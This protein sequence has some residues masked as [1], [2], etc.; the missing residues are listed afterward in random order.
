[1]AVIQLANI[2]FAE[3]GSMTL[4]DMTKYS[5]FIAVGKVMNARVH[6]KRIAELEIIQTLKGDRSLKR[7]RFF[8]APFW[9]CDTSDAHENEIG[10]FFLT[11]DLFNDPKEKMSTYIDSD[12]LPVFFITHSGRGRMIFEHIDG[13]DYVYA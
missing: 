3:A 5:D 13:Q 9:A 2:A 1:V 11:N 4:A 10:L 12:G 8:A 6:G 7:I